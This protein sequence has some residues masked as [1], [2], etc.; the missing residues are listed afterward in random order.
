MAT[1]DQASEILKRLEEGTDQIYSRYENLIRASDARYDQQIRVLDRDYA[2]AAN[3]ASARAKIDLK[4]TLEKMADGGYVRS[5]ETV[6]AHLSSN[7]ARSSALATLAAQKNKDRASF[8]TQKSSAALELSA[9]GQEEAERWRD[10]MMES[11]RDQI[12][13]DRE[14]EAAEKQ[15]VLENQLKQQELSLK[16]QAASSGS[17]SGSSS[18]SDYTGIVP[19]KSAYDYLKEIVDRYTTYSPQKDY[20]VVDRKAILQAL[21]HMIRDTNLSRQYRYELYLYGKT[22]GYIPTK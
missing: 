4:N 8:E 18:D 14:F 21:N 16:Q 2:D 1:R 11:Y 3:Q 10:N 13:R 20:K 22:M 17:S 9:K 15:R 12:N 19:K 7:A 5:G 6:Q